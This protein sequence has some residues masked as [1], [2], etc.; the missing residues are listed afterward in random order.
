M[1]RV[2]ISYAR[3]DLTLAKEIREWLRAATHEVF[4]DEA[5]Q[6][7]LRPGEDWQARLHERLRWADAVVC[8]V[9]DASV[10]SSWCI[11]ELATAFARGS[12]LIPLQAEPWA[13]HPFLSGL[14]HINCTRDL[15]EARARLLAELQ[16]VDLAGGSGWPDDRSPFPGLRPFDADRRR[17]FFGRKLEVN[18]LVTLLQSPVQ[19]PDTGLV[20]IIGPSGCGKSSLVRAGLLPAM[21][22]QSGWWALAPMLPGVD[23]VAAL[24]NELTTAAHAVGHPLKSADIRRRL[25]H[26]GGLLDL[27]SDLLEAVPGPRRTR[28]LLVIDQFEELLTQTSSTERARFAGV[29]KPAI[30]NNLGIVATLRPEFLDPLLVNSELNVLDPGRCIFALRPLMQDA[31]REM[32]KKNRPG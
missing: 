4:L 30:S 2:F 24:T 27:I 20:L 16:L 31:L 21:V 11:A 18:R 9:S 22:C 32:M 15:G 8:L 17:V 7:G 5:L 25:E 12:H 19:R 26:A 10:A 6:G 23:P 29:L 28:L 14:Q 13:K 1:A 3:V